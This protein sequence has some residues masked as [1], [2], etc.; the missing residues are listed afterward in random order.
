MFQKTFG[1]HL[2]EGVTEHFTRIVLKEQGLDPGSAYPDELAMADALISDLGSDGEDL[3]R[4]AY[5]QGKTEAQKRVNAALSHA[6]GSSDHKDWKAATAQLHAA[7]SG[8]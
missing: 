2:N 1:H 5:F 8:P 7:L 3:I 6:K 4:Q